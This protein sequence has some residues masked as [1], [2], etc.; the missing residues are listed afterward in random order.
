MKKNIL[1]IILLNAFW[2][3]GQKNLT[4]P[5]INNFD[6]SIGSQSAVNLSNG[7]LSI[8]LQLVSLKGYKDLSVQF[9][10]AYD[11]SQIAKHAKASN[12]II[13]T[14]V[15]GLGWGMQMPR[16]L[17]DN[18]LTAARDDDAFY[19]FESGSL[20]LLVA[21][22]KTTTKIEFRTKVYKPWKINFYP[23]LEKWEIIKDNG[24]TYTYDYVDWVLYWENWIGNSNTSG[25][26]RQGSGWSLTSVEDLH[27]NKLNYSYFSVMRNLSGTTKEH[28]EAT[29]LKSITGTMGERV[30]LIYGDKTLDEFYEPNTNTTEPDAYQ[31]MYETKYLSSV[32]AYDSEDLL[33]Y[34]YN[35][36][37]TMIGSGEYKKRLLNNIDFVNAS[38]QTQ[39]YRSFEYDTDITSDF[40]GMLTHQTLPTKGRISYQYAT[41]EVEVDQI[42]SI[43]GNDKSSFIVQKNYILKFTYSIQG[44]NKYLYMYRYDWDGETW[45]GT[46]M[47]KIWGIQEFDGHLDV[48]VLA[49]EN[50]FVLLYRVNFFNYYRKAYGLKADG[51]TWDDFSSGVFHTPG[52]YDPD[53]ETSE[54]VQLIGGDDFYAIGNPKQDRINMYR[55]TG[56]NWEQFYQYNN[57]EGSYFYT[58]TNNYVI[59]HN[60]DT[61]PDTVKMFYYDITKEVQQKSFNTSL[62]T[63]GSGN[64]DSYWYGS[65]SFAQVNAN[66]NPEYFIRWDKNYNF[67]AKDV[68]PFGAIPDE[69]KTQGYYNGYFVSSKELKFSFNDISHV[70]VTRYTGNGNWMMQT[71]VASQFLYDKNLTG[72]GNDFYVFPT[73]FHHNNPTSSNSF[74]I[75]NANVASWES[76]TFPSAAN[77]YGADKLSFDVFGNNYAFANYKTYKKTNSLTIEEVQPYATNTIFSKSDGGNALYISSRNGEESSGGAFARLLSVTHEDIIED[78]GLPYGLFLRKNPYKSFPTHAIGYGTFVLSNLEGDSDFKIYRLI[79][80]KIQYNSEGKTIQKD[81]VITK[82]TFDPVISRKQRKYFCLSNPKVDKQNMRVFYSTVIQQ[83]DLEGILGSA[84]SFYDKGD[85][86]IRRQGLPLKTQ[87]MDAQNNILSQQENDWALN[88]VANDGSYYINLRRKETHAFEKG[89]ELI[90]REFYSYKPENGLLQSQRMEDSEGNVNV[91]ETRYLYEEYPQVL[92]YNLLQPILYTRSYVDDYGYSNDTFKTATAVNWDISGVPYPK[93]SYGWNGTGSTNFDFDSPPNNFRE[94]QEIMLLDAAGNILQEKNRSEVLTSYI[95]GYGNKRLVAKIK[96][97][98]YSEAIA[99]LNTSVISNPDNDN[100]LITEL[101]KLRDGLPEAYVT[102]YTYH[103]GVGM[104]SKTDIRGRTNKYVYDDFYRLSHIVNHEGH[105]LKKNEYTY[106]EAPF[107]YSAES[108]EVLD[109]PLINTE[110]TGDP[111]GKEPEPFSISLVKESGSAMNALFVIRTSGVPTL[112]YNYVWNYTTVSGNVVN[113]PYSIHSTNSYLSSSNPDCNEGVLSVSVKAVDSAGN[114]LASSNIVNHTYAPDAINCGNQ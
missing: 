57:T 45:K 91:S 54:Y 77:S 85:T 102:S 55:W 37:Y 15:L 38:N 49:R 3:F 43:S 87:I 48:Q 33:L 8:P 94:H 27:G 96:G 12:E 82:E 88:N 24:Y 1:I 40:Y 92:D 95:Y 11:G 16:I 20:N 72:F 42:F 111:N 104:T 7:K 50:F 86:D 30:E 60:K 26:E 18:K 103:L 105:I 97:A 83:N 4:V 46:D 79:D 98:T 69:V 41:K 29:Y 31:E 6:K 14:G 101:Q 35:I 32:E 78:I 47:G 21:T 99:L 23:N 67:L 114:T 108:T 81:V 44:A 65:N 25:A 89:K 2:V 66:A 51:V 19:L 36:F 53:K 113:F 59:Q 110:I 76:Q 70:Y 13:P 106:R 22:S 109:C 52:C 73:D 56:N 84:V 61:S 62:E 75:F 71:E 63:S 93:K 39:A 5:E 28:T 64:Y 68:A 58:A 9:G 100:Q 80:G 74:N 112:G 10:I 34:K 90:T 107:A 17:A